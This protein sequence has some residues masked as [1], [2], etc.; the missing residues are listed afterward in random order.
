MR[1]VARAVLV[2]IDVVEAAE[3]E[4]AEEARAQG[5]RGD[6]GGQAQTQEHFMEFD[7]CFVYYTIMTGSEDQKIDLSI[8]TYIHTYIY[9]YIYFVSLFTNVFYVSAVYFLCKM[10]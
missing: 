5:D 3:A 7:P 2:Y 1:Q 8:W 10:C 6:Q 9:I 4:E